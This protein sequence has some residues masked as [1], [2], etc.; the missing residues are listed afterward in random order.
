[1]LRILIKYP[2]TVQQDQDQKKNI[3][4]TKLDIQ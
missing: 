3:T 1:M 4:K 2:H